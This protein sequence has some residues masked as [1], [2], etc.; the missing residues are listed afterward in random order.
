MVNRK[1]FLFQ[2]FGVLICIHFLNFDPVSAQ[3]SDQHIGCFGDSITQGVPYVGSDG[4]GRQVG[5]YEPHLESL[6]DSGG[7]P[8][9]VY[10]WGDAGET[11][12]QGVNRIDN[13]LAQQDF[14][15]MLILEGTNDPG[16][17][18][19]ISTTKANLGLM[20][21]ACVAKGIT[22]YLG[23]LTPDTRGAWEDIKDIPDRMNPAITDLATAKGITLVDLYS[24]TVDDWDNLSYDYLHPN[25]QG[26][27]VLA[28]TWY[29]ALTSSGSGGSG[30]GGGGGGCFIAT[31]AFGS[32]MERH[33]MVLRKF[34]DR[35]LLP[36]HWGRKL[37]SLYYHYS[38]ELASYIAEHETLKRATRWALLPVVGLSALCLKWGGTAMLMLVFGIVMLMGVSIHFRMQRRH[39]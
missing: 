3:T 37:V 14:N 5:G 38:P 4:D 29:S 21:D 27:Q 32:P 13:V 36:S 35:V 31:A 6:M 15:S 20:I 18:I 23:T 24:A 8:A 34:R 25:N 12:P 30:G 10:N 28:N 16:S 2:L 9:T 1:K 19:S 7:N 26:Y 17:G 11:T 39:H 33:V 22:P